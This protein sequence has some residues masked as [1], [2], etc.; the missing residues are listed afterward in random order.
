MAEKTY[1]KHAG[2]DN[3][4]TVDT[5]DTVD[6]MEGMISFRSVVSAIRSG[7]SDRRIEKVFFDR[8]KRVKYSRH[9]SFI[10]AM[11]HELSFEVE[12]VDRDEIDLMSNGSSHGGIITVC[13]KRH[14]KPIEAGDIVRSG[15]YYI[16][17]GLEDPYNFGYSLRSIYASGA[18]GVI[19]PERDTLDS[20]ATVSR[21][22][23][24][25]SELLPIYTCKRE[26][27]ISVFKELEYTVAAADL[28]DAVPMWDADLRA[29]IVAVIGGEKRGISAEIADA[30]DK[31]V[32]IEYG[33]DFQLSL[34]AASAATLLSFEILRQNR[35]KSRGNP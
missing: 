23:A 35:G 26:S 3:T 16:L 28:E 7:I 24:G 4:D 17:D 11:S 32:S 20:A 22:S 33:R 34:S 19:I 1:K 2:A 10:V 29:P 31:R 12:F 9:L 8:D 21:S 6:I 13:T 25:A 27:V 30:C 15:V 5:I 18:D 14:L